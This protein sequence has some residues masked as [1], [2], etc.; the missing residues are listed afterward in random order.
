MPKSGHIHT[1]RYTPNQIL[2]HFLLY[3]RPFDIQQGVILPYNSWSGKGNKNT[4]LKSYLS[5]CQVRER[6]EINGDKIIS[7]K[8]N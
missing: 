1:Q 2:T 8:G 7:T 6:G 3:L 5:L 4:E